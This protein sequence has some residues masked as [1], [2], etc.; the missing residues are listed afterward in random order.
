MFY[1]ND[2]KNGSTNPTAKPVVLKEAAATAWVDG[3]DALGATVGHFCMDVAI[4]K[5]KESGIGFV[6]AKGVVV[7]TF[8]IRFHTKWFSD[9]SLTSAVRHCFLANFMILVKQ[10][11]LNIKTLERSFKPS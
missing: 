9:F 10:E 4:K 7:R 8:V 5:A 3:A 11:L 1:I 6:S 2:I